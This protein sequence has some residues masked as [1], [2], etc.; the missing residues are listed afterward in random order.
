MSDICKELEIILICLH[1]N[2]TRILQPADVAA[3]KMEK[4]VL[5]WRTDNLNCILGND[6][7]APILEGMVKEY[8]RE[9]TKSDGFRTTGLFPFNPDSTDFSKCLEEK[10]Q[11]Q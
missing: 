3:F 11:K 9:K 4:G 1:L 7:F 2:A 5:K 10:N 6:K 8:A